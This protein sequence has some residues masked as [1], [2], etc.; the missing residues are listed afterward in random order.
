MF[1]PMRSPGTQ[2]NSTF[3]KETQ[4]HTCDIRTSVFSYKSNSVASHKQMKHLG[5]TGWEKQW[6]TTRSNENWMYIECTLNVECT[7]LLK[8]TWLQVFAKIAVWWSDEFAIWTSSAT[9]RIWRQFRSRISQT[10]CMRKPGDTGDTGELVSQCFTNTL[11]LSSPEHLKKLTSQ[12]GCIHA[13]KRMKNK[14]I[15]EVPKVSQRN[16]KNSKPKFLFF[17]WM[18]FLCAPQLVT[19]GRLRWCSVCGDVLDLW[20]RR[21]STECRAVLEQPFCAEFGE[22]GRA[23]QGMTG[24]D[25]AWQGMAEGKSWACPLDLSL[26]AQSPGV[27]LLLREMTA[28]KGGETGS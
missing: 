7:I 6:E 16:G 9:W 4:S 20:P 11:Q 21:L 19:S 24:H 18:W 5:E 17:A 10:N 1:C 2:G 12:N 14:W 13:W 27:V 25:R 8:S 22:Q 15:S 23:W 26:S 28:G 3:A